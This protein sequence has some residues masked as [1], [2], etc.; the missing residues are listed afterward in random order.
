MKNRL[1]LSL[2]IEV[3]STRGTN[4]LGLPA[5]G[6][7]YK[8]LLLEHHSLIIRLF[9]QRKQKY[10]PLLKTTKR[11]L[12][13]GDACLDEEERVMLELLIILIDNA[14]IDELCR[15]QVQLSAQ[16]QKTRSRE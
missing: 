6:F 11:C 5:N 4:T 1:F 3:D 8:V 2:T 14:E 15:S 16:F 13:I 9:N 12:K 10:R 7:H